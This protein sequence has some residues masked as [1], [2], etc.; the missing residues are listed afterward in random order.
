MSCKVMAMNDELK[1]LIIAKMDE[2]S[3]LDILG[4]D[5]SDLVNILEEQIEEAKQE[6]YA[7]VGR[8]WV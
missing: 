3:L 1:D 2:M 7:V 6:L 8:D 5:I 4:L